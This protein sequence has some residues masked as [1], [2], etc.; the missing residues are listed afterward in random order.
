L[1]SL[2]PLNTYAL[3]DGIKT[4]IKCVVIDAGHGG[5]DPGTISPDGRIREKN[6]ALAVALKFG[7]ALKKRYPSIKVI[8]TRSNDHFVKLYERSDIANRNKADLFISLHVNSSRSASA[9]GTE[10]WVMGPNKNERNFE[11]CKTENSVITMENDYKAKYEGFDPD[12]PESYI[13]FSLLQNTHLKNSLDFAERVQR[14]F[15]TGP[16]TVNRGVKQGGLIVLWRSTMPAVLVEL[17]F[18][19]NYR[20][21]KILTSTKGQNEIAA[22][23]LAAFSE[24][25]GSYEKEY[26]DSTGGMQ[27]V[28]PAKNT[29]EKKQYYSIQVFAASKKVKPSNYG[30][31]ENDTEIFMSGPY[32]K[33]VTGKYDTPQEANRALKKIRI[34]FKDAFIVKIY[35]NPLTLH[36]YKKQ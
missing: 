18:L 9:R 35:G 30:L 12:S 19:S 33:Y 26:D 2:L 13:I 5:H 29:S 34:K 1:F 32:Y 7:R 25:K 14:K 23:L 22:K 24:Y 16:I 10:T 28:R 8:Y 36:P 17:G 21:R 27:K 31:N 15:S 11:L 6:I 4:E 3:Q 20:D